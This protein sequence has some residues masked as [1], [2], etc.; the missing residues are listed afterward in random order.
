[1][2]RKLNLTIATHKRFI[3]RS[4]DT[5]ALNPDAIPFDCYTTHVAVFDIVHMP[6]GPCLP[7][8]LLQDCNA[9]ENSSG[10]GLHLNK[11][12]SY[13]VSFNANGGGWYAMER[14]EDFIRIWFWPRD[15]HRVPHDVAKGSKKVR[16]DHGVSNCLFHFFNGLGLHN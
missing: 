4:D 16:T 8:V 13:G 2:A 10:C 12:T 6:Q 3:L 14:T 11:T 7:T 5:T 1:M 9:D 15:D